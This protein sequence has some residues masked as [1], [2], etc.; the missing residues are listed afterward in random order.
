MNPFEKH[1]ASVFVVTSPFQALCAIAAIKQLE[2]KDYMMIAV[3]PENEDRNKQLLFFFEKEKIPFTPVA[4]RNSSTELRLLKIKALLCRRTKYRRLF[5]GDIR[6][7]TE[8]CV[9]CQFVS[10]KASVVYLDDGNYTVSVLNGL[11][12]FD[13]KGLFTKLLSRW[14]R[15]TSYQHLLTIYG[16]IPNTTFLIESLYLENAF[17]YKSTHK[18][19]IKKGIY[20][21]G[22]NLR[23]Y[24]KCVGIT[25]DQY[26]LK[27]EDLFNQL[28]KEKTDEQ[29]V[30][31]PHGRDSSVYAK[32]LCEKYNVEFRPSSVMVELELY[33]QPNPPAVIYGYTSSALFNLKKMYPHTE[34]YNI[35]FE[36]TVKGRDY[37]EYEALSVY[38]EANGIRLIKETV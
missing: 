6:S 24:S 28:C 17:E 37:K 33:Y 11:A 8:L 9:G 27:L 25:E 22:T 31:I 4:V 38:Y 26:T 34:V 30:F 12:S 18:D 19:K 3:L 7:I 21:V 23:L 29:I 5:V 15:I 14:R 36:P 35:L 2:I 13:K 10:N 32:S 20:I 1:T 16:D